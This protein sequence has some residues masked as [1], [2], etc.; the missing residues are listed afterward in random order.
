MTLTKHKYS[1]CI[2]SFPGEITQRLVLLLHTHQRPTAHVCL[3][4]SNHAWIQGGKVEIALDEHRTQDPKQGGMH[5]C[6]KKASLPNAKICTH[7]PTF[8]N[9]HSSKTCGHAT[10]GKSQHPAIP[11]LLVI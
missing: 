11:A 6:M 1:R 9:V 4:Q 2:F 8:E 7:A 5:C 10:R 3:G